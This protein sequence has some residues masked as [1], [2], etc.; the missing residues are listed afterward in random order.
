MHIV[1]IGGGPAGYTAAFDAARRGMKVSL[2]E[3]SS[4]GGICLN[5]GCI[6]AKTMRTS[7]DAL[8]LARRMAEFGVTGCANPSIDPFMVKKRKNGI[9]DT[10]RD[11]LQKTAADLG[12]ELLQGRAKILGPGKVVAHTKNGLADING[13]AIL[14]ATGSRELELPDL[15]F[16]HKFILNSSEALELENI[17]KRLLIVGGGVTGCELAFIFRAFGSEVAIIEGQDRLLPLPGIDADIS[18]ILAREMR[19]RKIKMHL[20]A[21]LEDVHTE[22]GEVLGTLT[23]SPF[24]EPKGTFSKQSLAADMV[25]VTVGRVP[26][27]EGQGLAECGIKTDKRGWIEVDDHLRTSVPGIY[28]AGDILGPDHIM[29]AHVAAFEGLAVVDGLAGGKGRMDYRVVPS[30]I[31]TEPEIGCV[32]LSESQAREK[33]AHVVCSTTQVR[34]LGKAQAMG[35]LPGFFKVVANG[36]DGTLLGIQIAGAHASDILAEATLAIREAVGLEELISTIH[37]HPT[38]AEG[39]WEAARGALNSCKKNFRAN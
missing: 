24:V 13:D 20:A 4:L 17:P 8:N 1:I 33:Y 37:A 38:L 36:D 32:G 2:V 5:H 14:I 25:F 21:T 18:S 15:P 12:I 6:P 35:E 10:L 27:S 30:A 19:K 34:E 3:K 16:D 29:L 31:F 28:A 9:I 22:N 39:M 11:G 7:A 26:N 23:A